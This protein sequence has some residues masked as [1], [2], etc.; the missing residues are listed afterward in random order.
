MKT[1]YLLL[2]YNTGKTGESSIICKNFFSFKSDCQTN[3]HVFRNVITS[4]PSSTGF[5]IN[6]YK[7]NKENITQKTYF[8][9]LHQLISPEVPFLPCKE[10]RGKEDK[11]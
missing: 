10:K 8:V 3:Q 9:E 5:L 7:Y 11:R 4:K 2:S 6:V 1:Q